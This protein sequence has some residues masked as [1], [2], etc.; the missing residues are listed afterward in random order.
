MD[1]IELKKQKWETLKKE[2]LVVVPKEYKISVDGLEY[3]DKY[4]HPYIVVEDDIVIK[5]QADIDNNNRIYGWGLQ[6]K[7]SAG[8]YLY[9][10]NFCIEDEN[11]ITNILAD[12]DMY[13]NRIKKYLEI[14]KTINTNINML[15]EIKNNI[16]SNLLNNTFTQEER[17]DCLNKLFTV[18]E[19]IENERIIENYSGIN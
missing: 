14:S 9:T 10:I 19:W 3:D 7:H 17:K 5:G 1:N 8:C 13:K 16:E 6:T 12:W 2:L 4:F 11:K 18:K 15:Q